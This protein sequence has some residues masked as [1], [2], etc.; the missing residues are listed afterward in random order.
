MTGEE[1]GAGSQ[2]KIELGPGLKQKSGLSSEQGMR[3]GVE[4]AL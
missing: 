1:D 4:E 2:E 3:S